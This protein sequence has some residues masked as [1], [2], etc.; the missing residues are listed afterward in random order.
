MLPSFMIGG[1]QINC[2]RKQTSEKKM[3]RSLLWPLLSSFANSPSGLHL[4]IKP[5]KTKAIRWTL[6]AIK[7]KNFVKPSNRQ[8]GVTPEISDRAGDSSDEEAKIRLTE[9]HKCQKCTKKSFPT[10]RQGASILK[11]LKT[12]TLETAN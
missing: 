5:S 4:V 2:Y 12:L 3:C 11:T 10:F 1:L 6:S 8:T 9:Y 7:S